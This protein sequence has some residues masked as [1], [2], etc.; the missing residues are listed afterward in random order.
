MHWYWLVCGVLMILM[1]FGMRSR[2]VIF[3]GISALIAGGVIYRYPGVSLKTQMTIFI[4]SG[5]VL[6]VLWQILRW[7]LKNKKS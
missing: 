7:R 5:V 6:A 3:F 2:M 4:A 1:E